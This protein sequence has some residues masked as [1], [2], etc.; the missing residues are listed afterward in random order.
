[1]R[2][3]LI[4]TINQGERKNILKEFLR[5][6]F[7]HSL[8]RNRKVQGLSRMVC[9]LGMSGRCV[10]RTLSTTERTASRIELTYV[11]QK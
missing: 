2:C 4:D 5:P 9:C 10:A 3:A 11:F 6:D 1:M 7:S 8:G